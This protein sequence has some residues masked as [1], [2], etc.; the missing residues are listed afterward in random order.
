MTRRAHAGFTLIELMVA[1]AIAVILLVLAAPAYVRWMADA[2]VQ[3]G[4]AS[5][6]AGIR[7]AQAEAVKR[8]AVVEFVITPGSGWQTQ[9]QGTTTPLDQGQFAAGSAQSTFTV[10][11]AGATTVTFSPLGRIWTDD[12][13]ATGKNLDGSDYVTQIDVQNTNGTR[14]LR[15]V[16]GGMGAAARVC[17]PAFDGQTPPDPKGCS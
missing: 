12:G 15:I 6:A 17:D 13:T 10:T 8:N 2:E 11:P 16:F 7:G 5:V 4:A 1:L 3:S 14:A 9:L